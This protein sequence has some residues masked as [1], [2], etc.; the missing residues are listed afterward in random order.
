MKNNTKRK[1]NRIEQS[2]GKPMGGRAHKLKLS[3][4]EQRVLNI[5]GQSMTTEVVEFPEFNLEQVCL[6]NFLW[7]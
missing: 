1:A 4:L 2:D 6:I 7:Y 3:D 5:V